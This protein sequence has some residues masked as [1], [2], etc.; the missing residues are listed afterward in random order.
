MCAGWITW[1]ATWRCSLH[2]VRRACRYLCSL[3]CHRSNCLPV[4]L[5]QATCAA[6]SGWM[7]TCA[8]ASAP[9]WRWKT[10]RVP[11][12]C[13]GAGAAGPLRDRY[14]AGIW[15]WPLGPL[16]ELLPRALR[17]AAEPDGWRVVSLATTTAAVACVAQGLPHAPAL[18]NSHQICKN[19]T[20]VART[21]PI[22]DSASVLRFLAWRYPHPRG[23]AHV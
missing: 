19:R 15:L 3:R 1:R 18:H 17:R 20:G 8:A 21:V 5:P 6:W 14:R 10:W 22:L 2:R 7:T 11:L 16:F 4:P 13:A 12:A 9:P 23:V